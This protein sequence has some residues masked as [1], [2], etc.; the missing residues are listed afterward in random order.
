MWQFLAKLALGILSLRYKVRVKGL[1]SLQGLEKKGG[2]LFL[3]NHPAH[4]DPALVFFLLWPRFRMR[5]IVIEYV[6]RLP[7]LRPIMRLVRAISIP[8]FDT[9]V[10]QLKVRRATEAM[11]TLVEGL[12]RRENFVL[13]P[14]GKLKSSGREILGGASALHSL[15]QECPDAPIVLIRTTGLWGSSFSRA[16]TGKSPDLPSTLR[17]GFWTLCKNLFFFTPRRNV[18]VE[19]ALAPSDFPKKGS[20]I[21]C[22]RFLEHWYNRYPNHKEEEPLS[23]VPP[24]FWSKKV[25]SPFVDHKEGRLGAS[26]PISGELK[27]KVY[28]EVR[29]IL[30]NPG[31]AIEPSMSLS[32]DL[33]MDS[34]NIA[35]L[36]TFLSRHTKASEVHPEDIETVQHVLEIAAGA[37][38]R[39][40]GEVKRGSTFCFPQE[41]NRQ[42]PALPMGRTIPEAFL[43]SVERM[44]KSYAC[45]DDLVGPL[46]YKKLLR[47]ILV[48]SQVFRK[49]P[50]K[51]VAV[52]LPASVGAYLTILALLFAKKVPV[53][54]N[55]TLGPRYLD[56]MLQLASVEKTLTSWRFIDKLSHVEFGK[57]IDNVD[58]LEDIRSRLSLGQKLRGLFLSWLPHKVLVRL[59]GLDRIDPASPCVILFTSG[60]EAAPKGVPLSHRNVLANQRSAMQCIHLEKRDCL[61]GILPPFHSFGF[62]VAG[63][64]P[65]LC[66]LKAVFFPDPTDSF[67]LAEGIFRWKVTMFCSAPSFLQGLIAAAT[68]EQI[69]S[70]RIFVSGAEKASDSLRKKVSSMVPHSLFAEG[71][72]ITECSPI[73]TLQRFNLPPHGVGQ[74]LPDIEL[75]TIHPETQELLSPHLEGEICV[76]GPNVFAGYLG[77][78]ASPFLEKEGHT[79]YKTGDIGYLDET[80]NLILTGRKKRFV[81]IGGEMVSL[82]AIEH[83]LLESLLQQG[84]IDAEAPVLA[85]LAKEQDPPRLFLCTTLS[86]ELDEVQKMLQEKGFS[87]LVKIHQ[88]VPLEE[89]PLLGS[90]KIDYRTLQERIS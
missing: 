78:I 59:L 32:L 88:I 39:A 43:Y 46:S 69:A 87:R 19:I 25:P 71:Y 79:W 63:L 7:L 55:W 53:M 85:V 65:L 9:S 37:K 18:E 44:G 61:Y 26:P 72:G 13:Y 34:L 45:A 64:F 17:Q 86:L 51:R 11:H 76:R 40:S 27:T 41:P 47:S 38:G 66:G 23:L 56:H 1:E 67:A 15:L 30:D 36:I 82:S 10:N 35:E 2:V 4:I 62:S 75:C 5:P 90:G 80:Q 73:L 89:I 42:G 6:Y 84:R 60:T 14:A 70:I 49:I 74:P 81:K 24:L 77:N 16:L 48:L 12:S 31:V 22:N 68:P 28:E 57:L 29:R 50:Q 54:L 33:G 83:V 52:L 3:P 21:E 58:M 8:N 20:R